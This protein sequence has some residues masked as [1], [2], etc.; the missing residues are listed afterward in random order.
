MK[1]QHKLIFSDSG[2]VPQIKDESVDL[3]VTSPA[4]PMIEMWDA[5]Y[6]E[7][8]SGIKRALKGLSGEKAFDLIHKELD[9]TW[10]ESARILKKGGIACVNIGDA[11]RTVGGGFQLYSNHSRIVQSFRRLGFCALPLILWHK[12]TNAPNKFM[13]S[14]MLPS[15]AYVTLEHEYV[16]VFRK[17]GKRA[18]KTEKEKQL[19]RRSAFFWEERNKWFSDIWFDLPGAPQSIKH[20][21]LRQRSAAFPLELACRLICMYSVQSDTVA[22]PFSGTG[23]TALSALAEGRNSVSVEIDESF[24]EHI[25]SRLKNSP[26]ALNKKTAGRL[27]QHLHFTK[28]YIMKKGAMRHT[29]PYYDFPVMTAQETSIRFPYLESLDLIDNNRILARHSLSPEIRPAVGRKEETL[30]TIG[31]LRAAVKG[32]PSLWLRP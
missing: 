22:D 6:G 4:Y 8:N 20:A 14:G 25:I 13:G 21:R 17:G 29:N 9:K 11:T 15:G 26:P 24:R 2:N 23:T 32:E 28:E 5:F 31:N 7:R 19:R 3:I 18:F 16:L 10:A 1:T 12:K 27:L 30:K